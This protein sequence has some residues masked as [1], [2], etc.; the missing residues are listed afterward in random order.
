KKKNN[1]PLILGVTFASVFVVLWSAF[2][3]YILRKRQNA[4]PQ[5]NTAPTTSTGIYMHGIGTGESPLYGEQTASDTNDS[6]VVQDE[7]RN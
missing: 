6:Y 7:Y 1:L 5:S 2:V 3:V 4:K